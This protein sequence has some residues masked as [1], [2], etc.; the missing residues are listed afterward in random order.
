MV[1]A[2]LVVVGEAKNFRDN[3]LDLMLRH[4]IEVVDLAEAKEL[5]REFIEKNPAEWYGD[6][7]GR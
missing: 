2:K 6:I 5:L 3:G 7:G 1:D 4:G